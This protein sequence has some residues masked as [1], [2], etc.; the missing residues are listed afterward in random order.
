MLNEEAR[1]ETALVTLVCFAATTVP[2]MQDFPTGERDV[3]AGEE[4]ESTRQE[5][6]Q[7]VFYDY[8]GDGGEE[9]QLWVG[10]GDHHHLGKKGEKNPQ[11]LNRWRALTHASLSVSVSVPVPS[12]LRFLSLRYTQACYHT[13]SH[14]G[15]SARQAHALADA[16]RTNAAAVELS[17]HI[18]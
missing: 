8:R 2:R 3:S 13:C 6:A 16:R 12:Y 7:S 5:E 10:R 17:P 9:R 18:A 11:R 1:G 15:K 4:P 14:A